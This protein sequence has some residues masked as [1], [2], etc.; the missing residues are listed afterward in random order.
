M[1]CC[2]P[3]FGKL[4]RKQWG[5]FRDVR[6]RSGR[7]NACWRQGRIDPRRKVSH[8]S[9]AGWSP[10]VIG[11]SSPARGGG[12]Q[13]A[14]RHGPKNVR[15]KGDEVDSDANGGRGVHE[16]TLPSLPKGLETKGT[17]LL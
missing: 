17:R 15:E 16:R 10:H 11:D 6:T 7:H 9:N 8:L 12:G 13:I 1:Q 2:P 14:E 3:E 5:R 4:L